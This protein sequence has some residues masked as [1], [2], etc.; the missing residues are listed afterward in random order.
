LPIQQSPACP[1]LNTTASFFSPHISLINTVPQLGDSWTNSMPLRLF[2]FPAHNGIMVYHLRFGKLVRAG[3]LFVSVRRKLGLSEFL[4][5]ASVLF[6][7][8]PVLRLSSMFWAGILCHLSIQG[9]LVAPCSSLDLI[10][11][12]RPSLC[13]RRAF[14]FYRYISVV[15][16]LLSASIRA[17]SS[18]LSPASPFFLRGSVS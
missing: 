12:V 1:K 3:F 6:P 9:F 4:L 2:K 15:W 16:L 14:S 5:L 17:P 8:F 18:F 13:S 7:L 11:V 10:Q